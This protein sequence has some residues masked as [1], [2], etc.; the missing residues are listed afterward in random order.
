MAAGVI[1]HGFLAIGN[2]NHLVVETMAGLCLAGDVMTEFATA[3]GE[4]LLLTGV[5]LLNVESTPR[6]A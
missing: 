6:A 4:Y 3:G 1:L 2:E 5:G